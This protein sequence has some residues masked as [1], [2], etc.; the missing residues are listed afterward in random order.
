MFVHPE[1]DPDS[2]F[3]QPKN[4]IALIR[5]ATPFTINAGIQTAALPRY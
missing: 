4:D 1:F 2:G 5:L 3:G